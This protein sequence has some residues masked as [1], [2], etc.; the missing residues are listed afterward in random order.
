MASTSERV[1][2]ATQR[3]RRG[4]LKPDPEMWAALDQGEK[5]TQILTDFYT[6]V[7]ADPRLSPF[8]EGVTNASATR[9]PTVCV[10]RP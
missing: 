3:R 2:L 5:L 10:T 9:Y 4:D 8:F 7:F 1:P 6:R